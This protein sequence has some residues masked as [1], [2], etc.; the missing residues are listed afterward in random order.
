VATLDGAQEDSAGDAHAHADPQAH[1][2]AGEDGVDPKI[3]FA[4]IE[5]RM[6]AEHVSKV[7]GIFR[8]DITEGEFNQVVKQWTLDL[9]TGPVRDRFPC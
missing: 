8:Y 6:T 7:N 3:V 4:E 5:S 2:Q 1:A 9:K